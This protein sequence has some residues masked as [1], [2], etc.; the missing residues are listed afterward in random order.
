MLQYED[1]KLNLELKVVDAQETKREHCE[2]DDTFIVMAAKIINIPVD[3]A[4]NYIRIEEYKTCLSHGS[5]LCSVSK[6]WN[7][8]NTINWTC[9]RSGIQIIPIIP[10]I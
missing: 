8:D 10:F 1:I 6:K 5:N 2:C 7:F 4:I 3:T 9:R